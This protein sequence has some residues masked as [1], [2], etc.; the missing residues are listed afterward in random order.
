M[1][2]VV[3]LTLDGKLAV[4]V[5][6]GSVAARKVEDLLAARARVRVVAPEG[7]EKVRSLAARG[8]ISAEWK[9]YGTADLEGAFLA[10]AATDDESLNARVASD[11]QARNILVNVVDRPELCTFTLPAV[12]RRGDLT[13]AV[14]TNGH[15][16]S[17]SGVLRD[18]IMERYG[19]EYGELT[20]LF[21]R[22]RKEMIAR[23][24]NGARIKQ[25][26]SEMYRA[27]FKSAGR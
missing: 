16:P 23:G 12:G 2:Y 18:E 25:A 7:C 17:F 20:S 4:V 11:A 19:P 8:E 13:F 26:I 9:P 1:G 21:G 6:G 24:W 27:R 3:N 10:V 5:G 22:L 15:C 14:S